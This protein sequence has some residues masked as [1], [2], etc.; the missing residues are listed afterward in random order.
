MPM[1]ALV[2]KEET[3]AQLG[4]IWILR[5]ICASHAQLVAQIVLDWA[6]VL[7]AF[8][9]FSNKLKAPMWS[10]SAQTF[11]YSTGQSPHQ[12]A[13]V[14]PLY[15]QTARPASSLYRD[16]NAKH[17]LP[18]IFKSSQ[19]VFALPV[20]QIAFS[21]Q[22]PPNA[23]NAIHSTHLKAVHVRSVYHAATTPAQP[24]ALI[25][26]LL[27]ASHVMQDLWLILPRIVSLAQLLYQILP[28]SNVILENALN[29]ILDLL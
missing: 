8:H 6:N 3:A 29:A 24:I 20:L 11:H 27:G 25:A 2:I 12:V 13:S 14:A 5:Q 16:Q 19:L 15:F 4:N 10:A 28:V 23:W 21:A 22:A 1:I 18:V 7:S 17:V 26:M 9:L